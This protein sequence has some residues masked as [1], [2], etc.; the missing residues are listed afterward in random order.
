MNKAI[1]LIGLITISGIVNAQSILFSKGA[2]LEYKTYS[3]RPAG[4]GS[5]ELYEVTR[6]TLTVTDVT[7]S[8]GI[9]YAH[10]TKTGNSVQ[11]PE[12]NSYQK[13]YIIRQAN[14]KIWMPKDLITPDTVYLS[15]RYP[16]LKKGSGWHAVTIMKNP[17]EMITDA[18]STIKGVLGYSSEADE[19]YVKSRDFVVEG[20]NSRRQ[21]G[22]EIYYGGTLRT[23]DYTLHITSV[24]VENEGRT[25]IRV[26]AGSFKCIKL[27]TKTKFKIKGAG[28]VGSFMKPESSSVLY[29]SPELGIL[30]TEDTSGKH[31]TG[32]IELVRVK[33]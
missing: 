4:I 5:L 21:A 2:E 11:R 1:L 18:D 24:E 27:S 19:I 26:K 8:N 31:Q 16:E 30:K 20:Q 14:N 28:L 3:S 12:Q 25:S 17:V 10:I 13:K 7:D 33:R 6:I 23:M 15:D 32:Y 22:D 9:K 29:Y